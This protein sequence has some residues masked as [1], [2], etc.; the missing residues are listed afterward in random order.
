[1][2]EDFF[3][4]EA[5]HEADPVEVIDVRSILYPDLR[6][7]QLRWETLPIISAEEIQGPSFLLVKT[8]VEIAFL[9]Y[10]R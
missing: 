7:I 9:R 1:M 5:G 8:R 6:S 10:L 2:H 4:D 3:V